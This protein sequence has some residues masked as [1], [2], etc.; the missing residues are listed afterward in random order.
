MARTLA[1]VWRNKRRSGFIGELSAVSY[2]R[3]AGRYGEERRGGIELMAE[4]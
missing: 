3:S 1:E 4:S 2:Q